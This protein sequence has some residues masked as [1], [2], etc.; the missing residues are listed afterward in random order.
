MAETD[1]PTSTGPKAQDKM[2]KAR[3][4]K[5]AKAQPDM[6]AMF[7]LMQRQINDLTAALAEK[8]EADDKKA[9]LAAIPEPSDELRPGTYVQQGVDSFGAPILGKVRWTREWIEKTYAPVTFTPNRSMIVAPHNVSYTLSAD[10][11][12]TV[13]GI[14]KDIYDAVIKQEREQ[15]TKYRPLSANE[16]SDVDARANNEPGTK[17]WS[18]VYRSGYGLSIPETPDSTPAV[19]PTA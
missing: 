1:E 18:R 11:E 5:A 8:R 3:A 7:E 2:A 14:V 12:T 17:Q 6:S 4:A 13:P 10:V 16:T 15:V 19:E 9:T